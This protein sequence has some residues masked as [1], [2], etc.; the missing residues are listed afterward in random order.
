MFPC[1]QCVPRV[2]PAHPL[3]PSCSPY[4]LSSHI[5][6]AYPHSLVFSHVLIMSSTYR[7]PMFPPGP[8]CPPLSLDVSPACRMYSICS[9]LQHFPHVLI[10]PRVPTCPPLPQ[11]VSTSPYLCVFHVLIMFPHP[12]SVPI[13]CFCVPSMAPC[14][15][16]PRVSPRPHCVPMSPISLCPFI[17]HVPVSHV[18][19]CC[20]CVS[21][22]PSCPSVH[23]NPVSP[24]PHVFHVPTCPQY[25][26]IMLPMSLVCPCAPT[27]VTHIP[28]FPTSLSHVPMPQQVPIM[29]HCVLI[30]PTC[31]LCSHV[32]SVFPLCPPCP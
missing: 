16:N 4:L 5:S 9:Y 10:V 27:C 24:N 15:P 29:S 19:P 3:A 18:T 32:T 2:S 30:S 25:V 12:K 22:S 1:L 7:S 31:P 8:Q 20:H 17:C 14:P 26:P 6:P 11:H 13:I 23:H 28:V 21:I